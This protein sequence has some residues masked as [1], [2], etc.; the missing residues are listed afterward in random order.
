MKRILVVLLAVVGHFLR[1]NVV[2]VAVVVVA[3]VVV[4]VAVVVV[5]VVVVA[6][7]G[8]VV[9]TIQQGMLVAAETLVDGSAM[10]AVVAFPEPYS[11]LVV[12]E[13]ENELV[14]PP[15]IQ[16]EAASSFVQDMVG[17]ALKAVVGTLLV[18]VLIPMVARIVDSML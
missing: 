12:E 8:L 10:A 11:Y 17:A 14:G 4:A 3:A 6:L 16:V 9:R 7:R 15:D 1:W 5:V 13:V 18:V 2:V